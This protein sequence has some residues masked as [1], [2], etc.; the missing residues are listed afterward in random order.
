MKLS[1]QQRKVLEL[2]SDGP[3]EGLLGFVIANRLFVRTAR[4]SLTKLV[5]AGLVVQPEAGTE[6]VITDLGRQTL[7]PTQQQ[8]PTA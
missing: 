4:H 1:G 3:T 6:Y 2:L 8:E 5:E 7:N